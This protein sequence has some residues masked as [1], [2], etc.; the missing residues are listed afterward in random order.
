MPTDPRQL[1]QHAFVKAVATALRRRCGVPKAQAGGPAVRVVVAV[2]GGA[3]SVA[4]LRAMAILATR[5]TWR[6]RLAVGHVQHHLRDQAETDA[7]FVAALAEQL[8]L[9]LLRADITPGDYRGNVEATARHLRYQALAEMATSFDA[10]FVATA[11]HADDQIETMLMR[12]LRGASV[13]GLSGMAWRRRLPPQSH[14][15]LIR[16]MLELDRT[17]VLRFLGDLDQSWRE[18]QTNAD[19]SRLRGRL[20]ADVLPVLHEIRPDLA[21]RSVAAADHLRQVQQLI[22]EAVAR[23]ADHVTRDGEAACIDRNDARLLPRVVLVGLLRRL[24]VAAG[25]SSDQLGAR[26]LGPIVR[27]IRDTAGGERRFRPARH[28][29]ITLTRQSVRIAAG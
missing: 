11:H 28:V 24:L 20:R 1:G 29:Q 15:A 25:V 27:A 12:L 9:P 18:D 14:S 22:D 7:T 2:S 5:R 26:K 16:P 8:D 10:S 6:L 4:L 23:A 13:K 21:Q 3:D 19:M 17:A